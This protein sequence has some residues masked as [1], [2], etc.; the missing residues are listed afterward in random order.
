MRASSTIKTV[1]IRAG[2]YTP[3]PVPKAS[4]MNGSLSGSS[5][6]LTSADT[7][8]SWSYYPAD[9][10]NSA[11]IDGQSTVGQSTS[12]YGA[13]GNGTGCAFSG[14][15]L[16]NITIVGLQFQN[17]LYSAFWVNTGSQLTFANNVVHDL[18]AA[19]WGAG[20]VSTTCAPGTVV[21]NNYMYNIAYTGTEMESRSD[22][23]GGI[24][25]DLVSGNI[26]QNSCTWP[27]VPGFGNDQNGG[28][29][30]AIYFDDHIRP[31]S[32]NVLVQNNYIRDVNVSSGGAGDNGANGKQGCC[33]LAV[34]L[35]DGTSNATVKGN[36]IGGSKSAC[37]MIHS[38]NNDA[39]S[40]NICDLGNSAYQAIV[41][42]QLET[43]SAN[44]MSG[45]SFE[46]NIVIAHS[47]SAGSGFAGYGAP[48]N[49]MTIKNNV[50]YNYLGSSINSSGTG[51]AGSDSNP[52]YENP[53][54]SGWTYNIA[55]GSPVFNLPVLFSEIIGG[56]GLPSPS[57]P[58]TGS[59]PSC[60]Y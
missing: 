32:T 14:Y 57:M 45:N 51:G 21:K 47:A 25:N 10:Y 7:G 15:K 48:P 56:W 49:P 20:A 18:T 9:G 37:V 24:S 39:I 54:L 27:A 29:C 13:G 60:P 17:Y 41:V 23:P 19:A 44:V 1:Y 55:A 53:Q 35:D 36:V 12:T 11:I 43:K 42:Y 59:P 6:R 2:K 31:A 26:I 5:V 52:L 8:E 34:Y 3:V 22:C 38:G 28:D 58:Q 4:C 33:A 50:Y 40:D 16:S 46:N 30:G